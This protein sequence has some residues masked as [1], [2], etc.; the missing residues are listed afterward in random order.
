MLVL[1]TGPLTPTLSPKL[2]AAKPSGNVKPSARTIRGRGGRSSLV[3]WTPSGPKP[4]GMIRMINNLAT[5]AL[6]QAMAQNVERVSEAIV[7][8]T[9]RE[10]QL[11]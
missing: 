9:V 1:E 5:A 10:F 6:I 8:Q 11:L 2:F 4:G 3:P 7:G